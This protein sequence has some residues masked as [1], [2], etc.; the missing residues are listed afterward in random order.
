MQ[1]PPP[2]KTFLSQNDW[3]G[4]IIAPFNTNAGYGLGSSPSQ[5]QQYCAKGSLKE[6][7]SITGGYEKNGVMYVMKG[8]KAEEVSEQLDDWLKKIDL[9]LIRENGN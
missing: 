2:V 7:F 9:D 1:L 5:F 6:F 4:K 8:K 3:T